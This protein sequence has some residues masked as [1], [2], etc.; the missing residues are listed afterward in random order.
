MG[1]EEILATIASILGTVAILWASFSGPHS[2]IGKRLRSAIPA[3]LILCALIYWHV[4][5]SNGNERQAEERAIQRIMSYLGLGNTQ[6]LIAS[7]IIGLGFVAFWFKLWNKKWYGN[8]EIAVGI[9]SA[10][11]VA[12]S[13]GPNRLDLAKW[14]TLAGCAYIIARGLGNR[15]DAKK[16][17][18]KLLN[19]ATAPSINP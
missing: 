18:E 5:P 2:K 9:L 4:H 17:A 16:E 1:F 14:S 7:V 10:V 13:L 3:I 6:L 8:V 15:D 11:V 19:S 12:R